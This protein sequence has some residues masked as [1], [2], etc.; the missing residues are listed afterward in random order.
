MHS[1]ILLPAAI[2][3]AWS[4]VMLLWT[5]VTRM[6]ALQKSGIDLA[7][8]PPGG[9][10]EAL[11]GVLPD[12]VMWKSHN[13]SHLME[14]PTLFYAAVAILALAGA[15]EGL[16]TQLAWDY[17]VLRIVHSLWQAT[18]NKIPVR[19]VLFS[20]STLCLVALAVNAVR[21]TL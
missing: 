20:L 4:L 7:K 2:L 18:V 9:R 3:V 1:T 13:Y 16:N 6:P 19:F 21:A 8:A 14:Q 15:G 11:N 12:N 17:V 10:G 5:V